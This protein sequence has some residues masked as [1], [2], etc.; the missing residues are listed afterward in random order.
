MS[1]TSTGSARVGASSPPDGPA[2][3]FS[4]VA[5]G[6]QHACALDPAGAVFCWGRGELGQVGNFV[7]ADSHAPVRPGLSSA[8]R[9]GTG[10]A[11]SCASGTSNGFGW[12][13]CFGDNAD[14]EAGVG[15]WQRIEIPMLLV[16]GL[17]TA[18][19]VDGGAAFNCVLSGGAISCWGDNSRG[20]LGIGT[21]SR[22]VTPIDVAL[23]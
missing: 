16:P 1:P 14:G 9:I 11:H 15:S 18:S 7:L 2:G 8:S 4:Q 10:R 3:V 23:K 22:S 13:E 21:H 17:G 12:V 20:Q 5:A 6:G 19:I